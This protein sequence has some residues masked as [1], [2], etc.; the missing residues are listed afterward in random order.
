MTKLNKHPSVHDKLS[1]SGKQVT[2]C[3]ILDSIFNTSG[4]AKTLKYTCRDESNQ[5][6]QFLVFEDMRV[7]KVHPIKDA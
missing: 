6:Y 4:Q 7:S 2:I 3:S 5:R 1:I